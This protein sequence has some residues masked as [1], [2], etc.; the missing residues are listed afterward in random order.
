MDSCNRNSDYCRPNRNSDSNCY[1]CISILEWRKTRDNKKF[2]KHD[3]A[4]ITLK[5]KFKIGPQKFIN[6]ICLPIYKLQCSQPEC[7]HCLKQEPYKY[8]HKDWNDMSFTFTGELI[9][10][11]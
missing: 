6:P 10:N 8:M 11:Q 2:F 1:I 4:L 9:T 5:D 3:I 7:E